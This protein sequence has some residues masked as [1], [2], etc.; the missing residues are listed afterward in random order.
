MRW[1]RRRERDDVTRLDDIE[2]IDLEVTD[3]AAP[4]L[5]RYNVLNKENTGPTLPLLRR[6]Q[7]RL[8]GHAYLGKRIIPGC[9]EGLPFYAFMCPIHGLVEDYPHGYDR[10]LDCPRCLSAE[11]TLRAFI[12]KTLN[13]FEK[14]EKR[15]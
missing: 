3:S 2:D 13:T 12:R 11:E 15:S 1:V 8:Y 9:S 4:S 14:D 6:V 7:L 5:G 10:R